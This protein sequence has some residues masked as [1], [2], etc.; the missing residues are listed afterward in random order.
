MLAEFDEAG[1]DV[2]ALA[3]RLQEEGKESFNKAWEEM[4]ETIESKSGVTAG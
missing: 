4:L 2:A 1:I 3:T